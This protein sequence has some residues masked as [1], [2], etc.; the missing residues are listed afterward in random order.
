MSEKCEICSSDLH[1]NVNGLIHKP[2]KDAT[3]IEKFINKFNQLESCIKLKLESGGVA[4]IVPEDTM[5]LKDSKVI[6]SE[7]FFDQ[8]QKISTELNMYVVINSMQTTIT[9]DKELSQGKK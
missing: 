5:I 4:R 3:L 8:I 6:L 1:A 9:V 7:N 2:I